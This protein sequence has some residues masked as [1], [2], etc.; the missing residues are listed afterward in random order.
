MIK[1]MGIPMTDSIGKSIIRVLLVNIT[2]VYLVRCLE[3]Y[4]KSMVVV[5]VQETFASELQR[6][7]N[8]IVFLPSTAMSL[9][10]LCRISPFRTHLIRHSVPS[11]RQL[12]S[13][14]HSA[15]ILRSGLTNI[16]ADASPPP[17]LVSS[18]G[19]SGIQLADGL[20]IPS[21][22]IFLEG[23]VLL[24]DVPHP[25]PDA[26]WTALTKEHMEVFEL[27]VPRP[28]EQSA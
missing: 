11:H 3:L 24:W 26:P 7:Q 23:R 18:I 5:R 15:S 22:C 21:A 28:G 25:S 12:A 4:S 2:A 8:A 13:H 27:V 1:M 10:T 9:R 14:F 16:L 17:V 19:S 6:D 20:L